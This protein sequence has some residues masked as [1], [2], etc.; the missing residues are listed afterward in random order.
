M[1]WILITVTNQNNLKCKCRSCW[2]VSV[3]REKCILWSSICVLKPSDCHQVI[4]LCRFLW[5]TNASDPLGQQVLQESIDD[6]VVSGVQLVSINPNVKT[7]PVGVGIGR[8]HPCRAELTH[9]A[10][11]CPGWEDEKGER[12]GRERNFRF[13]GFDRCCA[14]KTGEQ[15]KDD[16]KMFVHEKLESLS[17]L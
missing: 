7:E 13:W 11:P 17:A 4:P 10:L 14:T 15:M 12:R 9:V 8:Q 1:C 5:L 6:R 3:P 16:I 2:L